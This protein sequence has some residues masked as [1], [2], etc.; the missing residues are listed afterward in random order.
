MCLVL[1]PAQ[2]GLDQALSDRR[3]VLL[4][5]HLHAWSQVILD[6]AGG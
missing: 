5:A 4:V 3:A 6:L 1:M 2:D